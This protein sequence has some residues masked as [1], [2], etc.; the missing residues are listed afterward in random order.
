MEPRFV[1]LLQI[2]DDHQTQVMLLRH[3][4]YP[5]IVLFI[6]PVSTSNVLL[7]LSGSQPGESPGVYVR[8]RRANGDTRA[9][10]ADVLSHV[11]YSRDVLKAIG[12][13]MSKAVKR[14]SVL[15]NENSPFDALGFCT[16]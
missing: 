10:S 15:Q 16:W 8:A 4:Q 6:V 3:R 1:P 5:S 14:V 13:V 9:T 11:D 12:E 7:H 2:P